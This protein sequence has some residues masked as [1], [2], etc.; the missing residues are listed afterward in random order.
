MVRSSTSIPKHCRHKAK[1][2]GYVRLSGQVL[3]TGPWASAE[4]EQKYNR[5]VAE[6]LA[7]GR[8]LPPS[9]LAGPGYRIADLV[10]DYWVHAEQYY[11]KDGKPTREIANIRAAMKPLLKLYGHTEAAE[12]GPLAVKALRE[13][14]IDDG[15]CR[16]VVNQ[17]VG[18]IKRMFRWA[19]SEEL[20]PAERYHTI[21]AVEGLRSGRTRARETSPVRPVSESDVQ[22]V[23]PLLPSP[24]A[25]MVRLQWLTGMRPGEVT[26]L[27][28]DDIERN[29]S[30]WIYRPASHKT[31]HHGRLREI[32]LGPQARDVLSPFLSLNPKGFLFSPKQ[33]V[34]ERRREL[35]ASRQSKVTPSQH[36]RDR[37][38]RERPGRTISD[39]YTT[40]ALGHSVRRACAKAGIP[41]W[42]PNQ[43]RHAAA[44]RI[45]QEFG[46]DAARALLGHSSAAV[47]EIY[48][49][50]DR[51][52]TVSIMAEVG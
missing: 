31:Q 25:A 43:L 26:S 16:G 13:E 52:K 10:A 39:R 17:R 36:E 6:W 30:G 49:E 9:A 21:Q 18:M 48:A 7:R 15:L 42:S 20:V 32:P 12:F 44:T 5:L 14:L 28:L 51:A 23:L 8:R 3:Y 35:R 38:R 22:A 33:A 45:R 19:A 47:T 4:A 2:L 27:R 11:R 37:Q 50:V 40:V 24:V 41:S 1:N 34:E 46:L 29:E